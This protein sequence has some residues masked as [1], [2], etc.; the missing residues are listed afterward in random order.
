M[1]VTH[2]LTLILTTRMG[3]GNQ[4]GVLKLVLK[5]VLMLTFIISMLFLS[6]PCLARSHM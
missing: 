4:T 3:Y 5:L 2:L 6:M 1:G